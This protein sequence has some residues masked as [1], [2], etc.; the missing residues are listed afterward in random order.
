MHLIFRARTLNF[1]TNFQI[2]IDKIIQ[3]FYK[4]VIFLRDCFKCFLKIKQQDYSN[5]SIFPMENEPTD[6]NFN[7]FS[8]EAGIYSQSSEFS[9]LNLNSNEANSLNEFNT[10]LSNKSFLDISDPNV[11]HMVQIDQEFTNAQSQNIESNFDALL[12]DLSKEIS[13]SCS[14]DLTNNEI[15]TLAVTE[16]STKVEDVEAENVKKENSLFL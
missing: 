1:V 11:H 10:D 16:F 6:V 12:N 2:L 13:S 14:S 9:F 5:A 7:N 15:Q 8:N 3:V 4:K